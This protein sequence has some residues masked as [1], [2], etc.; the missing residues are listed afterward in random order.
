MNFYQKI[1]M[2]SDPTKMNIEQKLNSAQNPNT[3]LETLQFLAT[4]KD[5]YVRYCVAQNPNCNQ[6]IERLVFMTNYKQ[7]Q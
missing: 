6:I 2:T 4:D 3:P 7:T 5:P 1:L